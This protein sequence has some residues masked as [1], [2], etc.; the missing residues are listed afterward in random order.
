M[1]YVKQGTKKAQALCEEFDYYINR[2]MGS[3]NIWRAYDKPSWTKV[4]AWYEIE[5]RCNSDKGYQHD[6][7]VTGHNSNFFSTMYSTID[8]DTGEIIIVKDT[9]YGTYYTELV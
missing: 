1:Q 6:L 2:G 3:C 9:A 4:K 5:S 7:R 8:E